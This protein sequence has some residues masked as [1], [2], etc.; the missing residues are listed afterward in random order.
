MRVLYILSSPTI[1]GGANKSF[2]LMLA[3]LMNKGIEP[4]V[5]LPNNG[6]IIKNFESRKI[7]YKVIY[8]KFSTYPPIK[9]IIDV[10]LFFPRIIRTCV[11]HTGSVHQ[12]KKI[13]D[14]FNPDLLHTNVGPIQ[15]GYR[16]SKWLKIPHVWHIREYQ[17]E[18]F[19][20]NP[21]FSKDNFINKVNSKLNFPIAITDGIKEYFR[22]KKG[23]RIYNGILKENEIRQSS[24]KEQY[25][26][27]A[28]RLEEA[29]GIRE[30]LEVFIDFS[31]VSDKYC[32]L[33]AGDTDNVSY[34]DCLINRVIDEGLK[35]RVKFLGMRNDIYDLM[36]H[37][38]ALIVPSRF[39]AF[40]RI[41]AEAMFNGCLVVGKNTAGTKEIIED[42][43]V[44][45]LY[46]TSEELL[47]ILIMVSKSNLK[48]FDTIITRAKQVAKDKYSVESNVDQIYDYYNEIVKG[49]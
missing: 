24:V 39:E 36:Y 25:F 46:N 21:L 17:Y 16:L 12:L 6:D 37:A 45:L 2:L 47:Q 27:F 20:M 13:V 9:N 1:H 30:L 5:I 49:I 3:G 29:K 32:L 4:F 15:V 31:K 42:D 43:N 34:R 14:E 8:Y 28:G 38:T 10:L 23:K 19:G 22:I 40:G 18:D 35:D 26:L 48:D 44:G 41:T 7:P 11:I 33:I